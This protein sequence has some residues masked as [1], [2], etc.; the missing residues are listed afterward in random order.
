MERWRPTVSGSRHIWR[1]AR[2]WRANAAARRDCRRR[3]APRCRP[4]KSC[5]ALVLLSIPQVIQP[6]GSLRLSATLRG[7]VMAP[8]SRFPGI[9]WV[10][11]GVLLIN[12]HV[13]KVVGVLPGWLTGKL[14]DVAG[15]IVAP[16]L[17]AG[18]RARGRQAG[19]GWRSRRS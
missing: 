15:L 14:S 11:L 4:S 1:S 3:A 12:D 16:V 7:V 13:L 6:P 10:A 8:M 5:P 9:W 18:W 2:P 17:A 19:A